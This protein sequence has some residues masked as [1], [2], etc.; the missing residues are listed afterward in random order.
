VRTGDVNTVGEVYREKGGI[1]VRRVTGVRGGRAWGGP[2]NA[3]PPDGPG[4]GGSV[5]QGAPGQDESLIQAAPGTGAHRRGDRKLV[6][7]GR[8]PCK[9]GTPPNNVS[10]ADLF[11]TENH[12]AEAAQQRSERFNLATDPSESKNLAAAHPEIVRELTARHAACARSAEPLVGAE[13]MPG[14]QPP[15]G[16]GE[17]PR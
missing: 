6:G 3:A 8:L 17:F 1:S 14:F 10:W 7:N 2:S 5:R 13:P 12:P 16:W 9:G 4:C 15:P 11:R